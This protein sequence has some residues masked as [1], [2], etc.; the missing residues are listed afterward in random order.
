MGV[1]IWVE[2]DSSSLITVTRLATSAASASSL[3][4]PSMIEGASMGLMIGGGLVFFIAFLGCCGACKEVKAC[5]YAV[6]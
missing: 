6:S 5:L 2:V 4:V 1:G 3:N